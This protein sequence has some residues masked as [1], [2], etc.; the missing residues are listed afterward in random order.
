MRLTSSVQE[1]L[2]SI[3][4]T[5]ELGITSALAAEATMILAQ[6]DEWLPQPTATG[7]AVPASTSGNVEYKPKTGDLK[8]RELRLSVWLNG[9]HDRL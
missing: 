8:K 1:T 2:S 5:S 9:L 7:I 6:R 4:W 3:D